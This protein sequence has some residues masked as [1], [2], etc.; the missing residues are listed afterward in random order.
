MFTFSSFCSSII[1]ENDQKNAEIQLSSNK[2]HCYSNL[3]IFLNNCSASFNC[4]MELNLNYDDISNYQFITYN[5]PIFFHK[6][7]ID[8]YKLKE[9]MA[10]IIQS[11]NLTKRKDIFFENFLKYN[12]V[13]SYI[14]FFKYDDIE[15]WMTIQDEYDNTNDTF[16]DEV[17]IYEMGKSFS[18]LKWRLSCLNNKLMFHYYNNNETI[19]MVIIPKNIAYLMIFY[20]LLCI[21]FIFITTCIISICKTNKKQV[22]NEHP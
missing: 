7:N 5:N 8:E 12:E 6:K 19:E 13:L 16:C 15:F 2:I 3:D 17:D 10:T 14:Y 11:L 1:L 18:I 20:A 21:I 4:G 9:K 22:E